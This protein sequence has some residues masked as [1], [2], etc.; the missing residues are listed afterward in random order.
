MDGGDGFRRCDHNSS[1]LDVL[2]QISL[3][4]KVS[5]GG[6]HVMGLLTGKMLH[7]RIVRGTKD[8]GHLIDWHD[9]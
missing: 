2:N 5:I 8:M 1:S 6:E 3:D 7:I 9:K 4:L